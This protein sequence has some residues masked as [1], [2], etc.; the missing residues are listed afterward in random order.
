MEAISRTPKKK[1]ANS[2]IFFGPLET[3]SS[4]RIIIKIEFS[5]VLCSVLFNL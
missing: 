2:G 1:T 4:F 3:L 5:F